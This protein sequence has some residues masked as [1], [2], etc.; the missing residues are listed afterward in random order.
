ML[1]KKATD[2]SKTRREGFGIRSFC[3]TSVRLIARRTKKP[4]KIGGELGD[5]QALDIKVG[6]YSR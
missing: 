4:G 5:R 2:P 6:V 1:K 3:R